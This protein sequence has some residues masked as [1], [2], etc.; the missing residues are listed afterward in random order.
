MQVCENPLQNYIHSQ[1]Q[2]A[3]MG[4]LVS[5]L[6][7]GLS[8]CCC[9]A[10]TSL[11]GSCLGDE[12]APNQPPSP[13]SGRKRSV[14]LLLV[15]L[16]FA[17]VFQYAVAPNLQPG[18]VV[19][20][21]P[22]LGS[23]LIR[24]WSGGC[25][26]LETEELQ[27]QCSGN[28]GVYR[29]AGSA[30]LFFVLA[31]MAAACKP[32]ANRGAWPAK[33]FLYVLLTVGTV[34]IPNDPIFSP[35][36]LNIARVGSFTFVLFQQ[37]ILID[38]AYNLNDSWVEKANKAELE[39]G[40]GKGKKWLGAILALCAILF[41]GSLVVLGLLF[42]YFSGCTT[43]TAFIA[44]TLA[45]GVVITAIQL[46]GEESSLLT[47]CVIVSY[48]TY[49][50]FT[51]VS[52]N[53]DATCNPLLGENNI[54]GIVLGIGITL[55]SLTWT[56][57]S[58]TAASKVGEEEALKPG[59][60]SRDGKGGEAPRSNEAGERDVKGVVLDVDEESNVKEEE[61]PA[62][63]KTWK[64]NVILALISC[65]F[66]MAL[67]GWGAIEYGGDAANPDVGRVS[68]WM[69]I[70]SQWIALLLY[71]W[72]LVAPQIFPDREFS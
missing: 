65:W 62:G 7:T 6:T 53:P 13:H 11:C 9:S 35:I 5:A 46:K 63:T 4:A 71:L 72:T 61:I 29:A 14:L 3:T 67:T 55:L 68:M 47:T 30:F 40:E 25:A 51:A 2:S 64:L 43:N 19:V 58:Y 57:W 1:A 32:T 15:A 17:F 33:Y 42:G 45:S 22:G 24:A 60:A 69:I 48:S 21:I 50:C 44:I 27:K 56:G 8:F 38:L 31:A 23:Y 54:A 34:F 37:I 16:A 41:I 12:K 59:P 52:K 49:L 36:F 20:G 66:A 28:N 26:G 70:I 18:P 39:E 10:S